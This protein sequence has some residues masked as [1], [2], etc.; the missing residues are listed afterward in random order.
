MDYRPAPKGGPLSGVARV[1]MGYPRGGF[2]PSGEW[3]RMPTDQLKIETPWGI[4]W[5]TCGRV[6]EKG[7]PCMVV[8]VNAD[9]DR[10]VGEPPRWAR[11][12]G[13]SSKRGARIDV[14]RH[15]KPR[16]KGG[17]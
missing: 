11:L 5:V 3:D 12:R 1:T 16:R 7:R 13:R 6:D 14:T 15:A 17:A 9:G 8:E 10:F 4:V 2:D